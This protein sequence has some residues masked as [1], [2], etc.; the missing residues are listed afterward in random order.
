MVKQS[1]VYDHSKN[2]AISSNDFAEKMDHEPVLASCIRIFV[3]TPVYRYIMLYRHCFWFTKPFIAARNPRFGCSLKSLVNSP[4][5]II[6]VVQSRNVLSYMYLDFLLLSPLFPLG[7]PPFFKAHPDH[8]GIKEL[9]R[10][11]KLLRRI[12][13][14]ELVLFGRAETEVGRFPTELTKTAAWWLSIFGFHESSCSFKQHRKRQPRVVRPLRDWSVAP[15]LMCATVPY[16]LKP[17]MLGNTFVRAPSVWHTVSWTAQQS[18]CLWSP[19]Q[20]VVAF[21]RDALSFWWMKDEGRNPAVSHFSA[22]A[23]TI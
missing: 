14:A 19:W 9:F 11:G 3:E 7:I 15:W 23:Q 13:A 6:Q 12:E 1:M 4:I 18:L 22:F 21:A 20:N 8:W 16:I 17:L 2:R 10:L 5:Q